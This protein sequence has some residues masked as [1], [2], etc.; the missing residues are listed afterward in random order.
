VD[1]LVTGSWVDT[2]I[3]TE[4]EISVPVNSLLEFHY[5]ETASNFANQI[6]W[7]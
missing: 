3:S 4:V 2:G 1:A 5:V 6:L 7:H